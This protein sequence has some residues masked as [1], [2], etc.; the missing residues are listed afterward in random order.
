MMDTYSGYDEFVRSDDF[1]AVYELELQ[2]ERVWLAGA[3]VP[4]QIH[5]PLMWRDGAHSLK[6]EAVDW[7]DVLPYR[8]VEGNTKRLRHLAKWVKIANQVKQMQS[9]K[10][11]QAGDRSVL[12]PPVADGPAMQLID[13]DVLLAVYVR[14]EK[15][16]TWDEFINSPE[17]AVLAEEEVKAKHQ[18]RFDVYCANGT[19]ERLI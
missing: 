18:D 3:Q 11:L 12:Y 8:P 5:S 19:F 16:A 2:E 6:G 9:T 7:I 1:H 14:L 4:M 17:P 10:S 13:Q 15:S